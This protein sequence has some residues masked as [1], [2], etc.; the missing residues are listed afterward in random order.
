MGRRKD[1]AQFNMRLGRPLL[2]RLQSAAKAEH[3]SVNS[4][5]LHRLESTFAHPAETRSE[6]G[7]RRQLRRQA[8][9]RGNDP[10]QDQD[11]ITTKGPSRSRGQLGLE[12]RTGVKG[13]QAQRDA[14]KLS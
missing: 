1:E 7:D 9:C 13:V 3:R 4:E 2:R 11:G 14:P 10:A 8:L 6:G 12:N 5:I